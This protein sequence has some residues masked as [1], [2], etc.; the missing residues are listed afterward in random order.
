LKEFKSKNKPSYLDESNILW[1][2]WKDS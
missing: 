2:H 1:N